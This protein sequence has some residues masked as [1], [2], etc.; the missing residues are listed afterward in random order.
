M[1]NRKQTLILSGILV[2]LSI[3]PLFCYLGSYSL[4]LWDESRLAASAYEMTQTGNP[5]VVSF[6]YQP[7]HWSVK[8]PLAIWCQAISIKVFGVNEFAVRFPSSIAV[9]ATCVM[10]I[11][12]FGKL[13]RPFVG[14][15]AS[16][17][18]IVSK[19]IIYFWHTCHSADYEALLVFFTTAYCL[20]FYLFYIFKK[21][22]YLLFFFIL[23]TLA[24]MTK[25]VQALF[26][27]PFIVLFV[28][29]KRGFLSNIFTTRSFYY[30]LSLFLLV[31]GGY[32]FGREVIDSGY[33]KEV[34]N[35]ELGGRYAQTNEGHQQGFWYYLNY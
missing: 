6:N 15:Y 19:G 1:S 4:C 34:Y 30:G 10:L 16:L 17:I 24:A 23:L 14:F 9:L 3:V 25:G 11:L 8:P 21:K 22:R 7:D 13:Q 20:A 28:V 2:L 32:Y 35:G 12:F 29:F 18:M 31:I 26:P 27:L 5:L 33:L